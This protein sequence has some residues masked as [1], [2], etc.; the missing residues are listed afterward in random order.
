MLPRSWLTLGKYLQKFL[1]LALTCYHTEEV[2]ISQG[3]KAS[4]CNHVS[5]LIVVMLYILSQQ[6][7]YRIALHFL[8]EI[9]CKDSS[10]YFFP[11]PHY[12]FCK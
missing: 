5:L 4:C 7:L 9:D 6:Q 3:C 10:F 8:T 12:A 2:Y 1:Y 11:F